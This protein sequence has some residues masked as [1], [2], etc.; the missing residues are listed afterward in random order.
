[1][2]ITVLEIGPMNKPGSE[3]DMSLV[4]LELHS[5]RE[6]GTGRHEMEIQLLNTL[7]EEVPRG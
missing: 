2:V 6:Q 3:K 4:W 1:M 7:Q 5:V